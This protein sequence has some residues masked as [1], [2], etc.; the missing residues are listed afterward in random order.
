MKLSDVLERKGSQA[1]TVPLD[2]SVAEAIKVM[3]ENRVG[4]VI[5]TS[6]GNKL[7]GIFTERDVFHLCAD[8]KGGQLEQLAVKDC[9]T[10][11]VVTGAPNDQ[12]DDILGQMT[13]RRF[14]RMPVVADGQLIGVLSIGDLVKAKLQQTAV[15]AEALRQYI[16]S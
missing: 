13:Q 6:D 10:T 12:V 7:L 15:E 8:G 14:R 11:D 1:V 3:Y 4:S 2:A 5:V 9:M 16:N